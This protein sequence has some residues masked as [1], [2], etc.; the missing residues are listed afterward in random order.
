MRS[1]SIKEVMGLVVECGAIEGS[2][3]H[4][5]ASKLFVKFEN[6]DMFLTLITKEG[7]FN[8]LKRWWLKRWCEENKK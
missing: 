7:R 4:F 5:M 6:R 3:E 1:E 8:W 2:E